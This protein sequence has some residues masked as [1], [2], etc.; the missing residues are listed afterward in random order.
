[1]L[2]TILATLVCHVASFLFPIFASY[3]ALK[4]NDPKQLTPLL[5]YWVVI[6]LVTVAESWTYWFIFW[7][8]FYHTIK[9]LFM[10]WLVLPQTQGATYLYITYV[11]PLLLEYEGEIDNGLATLH[12]QVK[13]HAGI[14]LR[15]AFQLL[16]EALLAAVGEKLGSPP[17]SPT[18]TENPGVEQSYGQ[19]LLARFS[20]AQSRAEGRSPPAPI[21]RKLSPI[22]AFS[23]VVVPDHLTNPEDKKKYLTNQREKLSDMLKLLDLAVDAYKEAKA[24]HG[25]AA[26]SDEKAPSETF[27]EIEKA[28]VE[29]I[30]PAA[31]QPEPQAV[32]SGV[33]GWFW[34]GKAGTQQQQQQHKK[35]E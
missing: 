28:D 35:T 7:F 22:N 16:K 23:P 11:H 31:A 20:L 30:T 21:E 5:M 3:K 25:L 24:D 13:S 1:M 12:E 8:P 14:Y 9:A 26:H 32:R 19:S 27:E 17:G 15:R 18:R 10:L 29:M 33:L 6:G 34:G 2:L 4:T